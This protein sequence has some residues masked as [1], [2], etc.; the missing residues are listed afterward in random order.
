[1]AVLYRT[2]T[3]S[4]SLE[5]RITYI[6]KFYGGTDRDT[7]GYVTSDVILSDLGPSGVLFGYELE[8][9]P[10]GTKT[11]LENKALAVEN[12]VLFPYYMSIGGT[13]LC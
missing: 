2:E 3:Y 4:S 7:E 1:M 10:C 8:P 6:Q 5:R 13:K 11:N 9:L 12:G